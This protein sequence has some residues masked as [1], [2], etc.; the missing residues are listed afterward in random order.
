M[1]AFAERLCNRI[2]AIDRVSAENSERAEAYAAMGD[3]LRNVTAEV[4]SPDGVVTVV[5]GAGGA[6]TD[7]RFTDAVRST[8]LREASRSVLAALRAAQAEATRKQAE[9]VRSCLGST[10][11]LEQVIAADERLFGTPRPQ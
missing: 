9:V 7:V 6:I 4:S 1:S 10:E 3:E 8:Q 2:D 11:E 5:A